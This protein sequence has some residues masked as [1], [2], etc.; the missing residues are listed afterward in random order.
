MLGLGSQTSLTLSLFL[1]QARPWISISICHG[2]LCS[3]IWFGLW[4][5]TPLSTIHV[6]QFYLSGQFFS[7]WGVLDTT[8]C[9]KVYQWLATCL[10]FSLGTPVSSTNLKL[11]A[12]IKL[13]YM[14]WVHLTM[15]GV[16]THN[17]S[18]DRYWL[19]VQVV[20]NPTTIRSRQWQPLNTLRIEVIVHFVDICGIL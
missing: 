2:F 12:K 1:F 19:H 4:C 7:W 17:F 14:Y 5:L 16:Q 18:G 6:F 8:L 13:K 9:D 3:I 15:K 20:V 10:W 11:T